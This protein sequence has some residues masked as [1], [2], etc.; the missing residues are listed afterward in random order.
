MWDPHSLLF[1]R[2]RAFIALG[3][4]RPWREETSGPHVLP[5][6]KSGGSSSCTPSR[7]R[8][9]QLDMLLASVFLELLAGS[10]MCL[11]R[12]SEQLTAS[13]CTVCSVC[14][15]SELYTGC[16]RST[17]TNLA[18]TVPTDV[19][20]FTCTLQ[21]T[22][23]CRTV[24]IAVHS[25]KFYQLLKIRTQTKNSTISVNRLSGH[26]VYM[27]ENG[28]ALPSPHHTPVWRA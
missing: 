2:S 21:G 25:A 8:G 14:W 7:T 24:Q 6:L 11:N 20:T 4:R 5:K 26:S 27:V 3:L 28:G 12:T 1:N 19:A 22:S 18:L 15:A 23:C 13:E 9:G 16:P 10:K 17:F